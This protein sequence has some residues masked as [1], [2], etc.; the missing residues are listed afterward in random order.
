MTTSHENELPYVHFSPLHIGAEEIQGVVDA[1]QSNWL[2]TGPRTKQFESKFK[3]YVDAKAALAVNSCTAALHV[4]LVTMGVGPGDEVI[5]SPV[6]FAATANVVEHVGAKLV[7]ADVRRDT[8]N[9]D[10]ENIETAI[11]PRTKVILPVH[12]AGH[13]VD[14]T[15]VRDMAKQCGAYVLADAAHAI[16]AARDG[17]MVGS[18]PDL[19]AFSFYTTKN[20]TTAEGGMLTGDPEMLA[21]ARVVS[22]HGMSREAWSRYKVGGTWRYDVA[23]PGFKYN[24]TDLQAA[25]GLVQLR[26]L[27]RFQARRRQIVATYQAAFENDEALELPQIEGNIEHAWHLYVVR[28]RPDVLTIDRDQFVEEL[29]KRRIG[30]SVHFIPIHMHS[31]YRNKYG[32]RPEDLPVASQEFERYF[33]LPLSASLSDDELGRVIEATLDVTRRFR[34]RSMAA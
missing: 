17:E 25:L 24:M 30:S 16:P 34:R 8:L 31:H 19:T 1:M 32:W 9:I 4:A 12:Y 6:T 15:V 26:K 13:P 10:L 27:E 14:M 22:L 33:S 28:V 3:A 20:M 18:G 7:L 29:H 2:T 21:R 5:T 11:T 23:Q